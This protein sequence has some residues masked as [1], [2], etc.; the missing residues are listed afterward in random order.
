[1]I[2]KDL[3]EIY[4]VETK[5]LNQAVKRNIER[6]PESFRFQLTNEEYAEQLSNND[7]I[8]SLRSQTVTLNTVQ[9]LRSQT[10][11]LK[12]ER[13]RHRKYLPY[14]FTEQGI[15]ML[16]AVLRSEVAV[17]VSIQIMQ[18]FVE[19]RRM[20]TLNQNLFQRLDRIELK[21]LETEN[22]MDIIFDALDNRILK[23]KQGIFFDG[24][25]YDAYSFV[26]ELIKSA[27]RQII[28]IDN[29]VDDTV[30][31]MLS[32]KNRNYSA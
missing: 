31:T 28:L 21:Q 23:P 7:R 22:K 26:S 5:V 14:V 1:M 30:L 17:Q 32:K 4:Q 13:G 25:I 19:M 18:A 29:Y 9:F 8:D 12:N 3:A 24:Q 15:A 6:F 10:V 11:T 2:D 16:S 20:L 27:K